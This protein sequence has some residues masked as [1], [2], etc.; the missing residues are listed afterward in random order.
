MRPLTRQEIRGV[1]GTVLLPINADDSI[2]EARLAS[3][4]DALIAAEVDGLYT[5]GTAGEFHTQTEDEFDRVNALVAARCERAG[6][7]FQVGASHM[8]AQI[9]LNRVRRAKALNPSA[10]QIILPDWVTLGHDEAVAFLTRI[11]EAADPIGLVLYNPPHAKRPLDMAAIA[12]L[13]RKVPA[14]IGVKVLDGNPSWYGAMRVQV[15]D[16]SVFV[17][18]HHLATGFQHG[19]YGSYSNVAC[20]SPKGSVR[21]WRLMQHDMAGAQDIERRIIDFFAAHIAPL[22]AA[23]FSNTALDKT[24]AEIGGWSDVGLRI[25]WPYKSVS[26][27][28][29]DKLKPIARA[30]IPELF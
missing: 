4:V 16:L 12:A 15:P 21:W 18:G 9:S 25:R 8:S 13:K 28:E 19:G 1:W 14:L 6:M 2:D 11:A 20:L 23:G 10:F 22:G 29:A 26:Q 30:M 5:N 27:A 17:P 7:P 3:E 24:L